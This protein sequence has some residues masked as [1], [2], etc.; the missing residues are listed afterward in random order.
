MQWW[1]YQEE[2][3]DESLFI[4]RWRPWSEKFLVV[5][6]LANQNKLFDGEILGEFETLDG[7]RVA[8]MLVAK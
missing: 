7:A 4:E 2:G 5:R 3:R 6:R 8:M 1:P